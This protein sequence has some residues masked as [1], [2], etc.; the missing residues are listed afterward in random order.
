MRSCVHKTWISIVSINHS[1]RKTSINLDAHI[2]AYCWNLNNS[3]EGRDSCLLVTTHQNMPGI[4]SG[5]KFKVTNKGMEKRVAI[6]ANTG[7]K[8]KVCKRN[9][10]EIYTS[11]ARFIIAVLFLVK[12]QH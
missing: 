11:C 6:G 9:I 7:I 4:S 5:S 10:V 2:Q 12:F 1:K 3:F 8:I